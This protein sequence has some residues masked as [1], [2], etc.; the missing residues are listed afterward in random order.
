MDSAFE[1]KDALRERPSVQLVNLARSGALDNTLAEYTKAGGRMDK[2]RCLYYLICQ[3]TMG[4][5]ASAPQ[6]PWPAYAT[7]PLSS[8][9]HIGG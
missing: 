8:S 2:A 4:A 9:G 3:P 5:D 7:P 6:L 1:A